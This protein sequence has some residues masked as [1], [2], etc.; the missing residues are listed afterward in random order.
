M[1]SEWG[2]DRLPTSAEQDAYQDGP[3]TVV[4]P[5]G[6]VNAWNYK[7]CGECG[8][9]I[10]LV[11]W[12]EDT[13]T[14]EVS[15]NSPRTRLLIGGAVVL[16]LT[17][18]ALAL[19]FALRARQ[20][21][22]ATREPTARTTV[23]KA[24]AAPGLPSCPN[25]PIVEAESMDLTADGLEVGVAFMSSC[26]GGDIESNTSLEVTVAEGRR[27]IAAGSFDFSSSP[28][29]MET[30]KPARRILIFPPGMYWRTPAMVSTSPEMTAK[31]R[32][33]SQPVVATSPTTTS[34]SMTAAV[35]AK[36]AFGSSDGVAGAV[37]EE[38]RDAD[39]PAVRSTMSNRWVPQISS[40][41]VGLVAEG[42]TW[43]NAD[44][45][46]DHL[47]LRQRFSGARLVWSG[48]WTTFN[49]P[50]FWVTVVAPSLPTALDANRW[51]DSQNFAADDCFAKFLS[52]F[53]GVEGTTVYRE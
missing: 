19:A 46:R 34:E 26:G 39:F 32:G 35:P 16:A 40:K 41:R 28:L 15:R 52:T 37:L 9:P 36:P 1:A 38:L 23:V 49:E 43:D 2:D 3:A 53:F 17:L 6:H 33:D 24:P 18:V 7:L 4:C 48:H 45:L 8:S 10:G 50:D 47:R 13:D 31:R 11:S 42:K 5:R 30:G 21:D 29:V 27:D 20:E 14:P 22:S 12:P 25:D 51:C 44:I